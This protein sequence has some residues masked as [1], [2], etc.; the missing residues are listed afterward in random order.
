MEKE[1]GTRKPEIVEMSMYKFAFGRETKLEKSL[2]LLDQLSMED[3]IEA[4]RFSRRRRNEIAARREAD[5]DDDIMWEEMF[6][7]IA[8]GAAEDAAADAGDADPGAP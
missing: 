6:V 2:K 1:D 7:V 8:A 3:L 4:I 5:A